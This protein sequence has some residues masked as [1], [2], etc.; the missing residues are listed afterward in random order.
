MKSNAIYMCL[1][2]CQS[3]VE[4]DAWC[5]I[6]RVFTVANSS[7][8]SSLGQAS[9]G[10]CMPPGEDGEYFESAFRTLVD[11][12]RRAGDPLFSLLIESS[13]L[14]RPRPRGTLVQSS[15]RDRLHRSGANGIERHF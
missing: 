15:T 14:G 13:F 7:K 11:R 1:E 3:F 12:G 8:V 2:F 6:L 4:T 5:F 10:I 9:L